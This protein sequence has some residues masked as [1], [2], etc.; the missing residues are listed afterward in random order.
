MNPLAKCF[1]KLKLFW[2]LVIRKHL[3]YNLN[4]FIDSNKLFIINGKHTA[5]LRYIICFQFNCVNKV[6]QLCKRPLTRLQALVETAA[7]M[8]CLR[9]KR[10]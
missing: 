8:F 5:V 9:N 10:D 2:N 3:E 1:T 7:K 6:T 4:F